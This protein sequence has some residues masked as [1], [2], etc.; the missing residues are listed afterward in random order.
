[1]KKE[2]YSAMER[3]TPGVKVFSFFHPSRRAAQPFSKARAQFLFCI[4]NNKPDVLCS[5]IIVIL[6][7]SAYY[8]H[9][10]YLLLK[11]FFF[12]LDFSPS[13][14]ISFKNKK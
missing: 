14:Y 10:H 6:S 2:Q 1:M 8:H 3:E 9:H 5:I 7:L 4:I 11:F 12:G 13:F